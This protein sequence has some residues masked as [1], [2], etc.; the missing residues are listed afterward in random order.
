MAQW[1]E[2]PAGKVW[3]VITNQ[4][5]ERKHTVHCSRYRW[6]S[7]LNQ[8]ES[9]DAQQW[10]SGTKRLPLDTFRWS[11]SATVQLVDCPDWW[12]GMP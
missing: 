8:W 6:S 7:L 3:C 5:T 9:E 1:E 11:G 10:S 2:T 4:P 12:R